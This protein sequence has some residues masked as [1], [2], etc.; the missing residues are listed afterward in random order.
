[1]DLPHERESVVCNVY[2]LDLGNEKLD[3]KSAIRAPCPGSV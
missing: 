3:L 2:K 1:M